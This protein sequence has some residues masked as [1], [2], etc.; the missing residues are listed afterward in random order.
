MDEITKPNGLTQTPL[1]L[2]MACPARFGM[3]WKESFLDCFIIQETN[4][5]CSNCSQRGSCFKGHLKCAVLGGGGV[6]GELSPAPVIEVELTIGT[7]EF[8][9]PGRGLEFRD[10]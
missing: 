3:I 10:E 2:L 6:G 1:S 4:S 7:L 9:V 5:V 8:A